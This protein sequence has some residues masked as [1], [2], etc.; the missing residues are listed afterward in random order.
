MHRRETPG[1][2]RGTWRLLAVFAV[3][4]ASVFAI[5]ACGGDDK[6]SGGG[7]AAS[8]SSDGGS[9]S[10]PAAKKPTGE[11]IKTMTIAAVNWNGPAYPNILNTAE[12]YEKWIN[13][14]G[15][16]NGHPLDITVCDE[17][18][19][20]NQ[21]ATCGRKAVAEK[22]VA[23][24]GSYTLTPDRIVPILEKANVPWFGVC[25]IGLPVEQNSPVTFD[26]GPQAISGAAY[27]KKAADLGCK[28]PSAMVLD[29][30]AKNR[31]FDAQRR[32]LA[33]YGIKLGATVAVP[34]ASADYAPQVAQA[35]GGGADC[36]IGGLTENAW[37]S[38]MGPF[39]QSGSKAKLIGAQGNLDAKVTKNFGSAVAGSVSI[40][41]YPDI[42]SDAFKDYRE[43]IA[44]YKPDPEQDYNSLGGL[45]T[46]TAYI[47]FQKIVEKMT[48]P[49]TNETFLAAANKTSNLDLDGKLPVLNL[50]KPWEK[51]PF[52]YKRIFNTKV[53]YA[54]F[55]ENGKL[56]VEDPAFYDIGKEGLISAGIK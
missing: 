50:T 19:D 20:P 42:S 43:A 51:Q 28:K 18:G 41:Y 2:R 23:V 6:D 3:L 52:G 8:G 40:N 1:A 22:M 36:I 21:L 54:V 39:A 56:K 47:G 9:A 4:V 14:R 24:V 33:S 10:T 25:C 49:I 7:G 55:D 44:Q 46:W 16:I 53:T 11:P 32:I 31:F 45:G 48:G 30:P 38:F 26:F 17:Q 37:A 35:T 15:G 5:A 13:D 34:V 12:T 27:A 29:V